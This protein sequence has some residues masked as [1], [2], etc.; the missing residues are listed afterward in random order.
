MSCPNPYFLWWLWCDDIDCEWKDLWGHFRIT[1]FWWHAV[2]DKEE[3]VRILYFSLFS[4]TSQGLYV[5]LCVCAGHSSNSHR[6]FAKNAGGRSGR[7]KIFCK[8]CF[9]VCSTKTTSYI[10]FCIFWHQLVVIFHIFNLCKLGEMCFLVMY[11][12][13]QQSKI[14]RG[15]CY[16]FSRCLSSSS[17]IRCRIYNISIRRLMGL[18]EKVSMIT[19]LNL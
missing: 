16:S 3:W 5:I 8:I 17:C 9:T 4:F 11:F 13:L 12:I 18:H 7:G 14:Q 2:Q 10:Y 1:C 6:L 15:P 19:V